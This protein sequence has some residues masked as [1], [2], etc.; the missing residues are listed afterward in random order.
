MNDNWETALI[1]I[2]V[3]LL[4]LAIAVGATAI[5]RNGEV[6]AFNK[7]HETDYTFAEWFWAKDTIRD[8][9]LGT[10]ENKN[11]QVDLN[12]NDDRLEGGG[13]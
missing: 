13:S 12:I 9:H 2:G 1:M 11:Y 10:V 7:I 3:I 4:L 5:A 8:Y 6:K